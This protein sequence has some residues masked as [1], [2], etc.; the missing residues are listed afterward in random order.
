MNNSWERLVA[1]TM[2]FAALIILPA[3]VILILLNPAGQDERVWEFLSGAIVGCGAPILGLVILRKQPRNRIGWLW[4]VIGLTMAFGSLSQGLKYQAT[5]HPTDGYSNPLFTILLFSEMT[6][7]I[8]IVCLMLMMLWFPDGKPPTPRWRILH[9]WAVV[10]FILLNLGLFMQE[11]PWSDVGGIGGNEPLVDNPIGFIPMTLFSPVYE[12]V[13]PIGFFSIVLMLLLAVLALLLRYRSAGQQVRMQIRW[14]IVGGA[15]YAASF[16]ASLFLLVGS[17]ILSGI[18][19]NLAILPFYLAIGFAI[20]RYHLY[21]IDLIIRKTLQYALL[22]GLL[23]LVYF[24]SVILLQSLVENFTGEQSPLVIVLSTLAIAA[25][26][27]PLRNRVQDFINRRFYRKKYDAE[28]ALAQFA[29]TARDEVDM[30]K[31]TVALLDVVRE[32]MQ[33]ESL[34]LLLKQEENKPS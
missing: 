11:V 12:V 8:Q 13:A 15:I 7:L 24:G 23:A 9:W 32:T 6:N 34:S 20:T 27:N 2:A 31:L 25:L 10:A 30:D 4:L 21:D 14:F 28:Q 33:S 3:S 22:T 1:W 17:T 18:L 29:A 19:T 16:L 26:F 5:S